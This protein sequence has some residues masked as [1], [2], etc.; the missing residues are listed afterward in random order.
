VPTGRGKRIGW[1]ATGALL[2]LPGAPGWGQEQTREPEIP[3]HGRTEASL[4]EI[5]R[6]VN[7]PIGPLWQ[8]TLDNP[9]V[10]MG[11]GG[12][13]GVE[14]AYTGNLQAQGPLWLSRLGSRRFAWAEDLGIFT[15]LTIPFAETVPLPP[16]NGG[17]GRKTG[18]G[19][20]QWGA[21]LAPRRRSGLLWGIGPTFIFPS[22]S[23][24]ALGQGKWQAGPAA[25][26]GYIGGG[27][28]AYALAQQ[29]WSFAGDHGRPDTS[30]LCLNYVLIRNLPRRWQIGMQ[31]SLEVDWK[32]SGGNRVSFPVGLGVGRTVRIGSLPVQFWLEADYYPVR[33]DDVPGPRWGIDLQITPV[34]SALFESE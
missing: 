33:P 32:A 4:G 20:I 8:L 14:P 28:T 3:L 1:I 25:L 15:R 17:D 26:A 6:Q 5:A 7:N 34:I 2:L 27:W 9:V 24:D 21:V 19:D 10:A 29:W 31:P 16:G 11:G 12:L 23:D 18:F 13:D 30:Q 22:A